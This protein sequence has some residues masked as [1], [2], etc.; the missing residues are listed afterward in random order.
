[1]ARVSVRY[2]SPATNVKTDVPLAPRPGWRTYPAPPEH[3]STVP[4]VLRSIVIGVCPDR[5][6][7]STVMSSSSKPPMRTINV[8]GTVVVTEGLTGVVVAV[9]L[10]LIANAWMGVVG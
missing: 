9:E 4:V 10:P 8:F 3:V 5:P 2:S 1:M 7:P 6:G